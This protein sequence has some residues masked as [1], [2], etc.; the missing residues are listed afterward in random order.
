MRRC[1]QAGKLAAHGAFRGLVWPLG[2][3]ELV[4]SPSRG[5]TSLVRVMLFCSARYVIWKFEFGLLRPV[6]NRL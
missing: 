2:P 5:A 6:S 1:R 4:P 3:V